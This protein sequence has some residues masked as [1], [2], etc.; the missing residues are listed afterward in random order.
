[1]RDSNTVLR[2]IRILGFK[3][4]KMMERCRNMRVSTFTFFSSLDVIKGIKSRRMGWA[5]NVAR[6]VETRCTWNFSPKT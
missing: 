3:E 5:S 4:E 6:I 2:E 1:M